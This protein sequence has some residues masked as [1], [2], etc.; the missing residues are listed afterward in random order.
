LNKENQSDPIKWRTLRTSVEF[1]KVYKEGVSLVG[2]LFVL[3]LLSA[4]DSARGV[5]ASK[6]VGNAVQRNR[7]KR[8]LREAFEKCLINDEDCVKSVHK[9]LICSEKNRRE[10]EKEETKREFWV[11][12][13]ARPKILTTKSIEVRREMNNLLRRKE[14]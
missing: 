11:V 12:A 14:F 10:S 13:I 2:R 9:R 8:L 1:N 4:E 5:V 6:K 7:A 3:Y